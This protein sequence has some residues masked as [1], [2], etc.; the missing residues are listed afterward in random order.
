MICILEQT[1]PFIGISDLVINDLTAFE[2]LSNTVS[3]L[4][5]LPS[6]YVRHVYWSGQ[7]TVQST[8]TT[9]VV[10]STVPSTYLCNELME[11]LDSNMTRVLVTN[12]RKTS[13][14]KSSYKFLFAI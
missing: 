6:T 4:N 8:T 7:K 13:P 11:G 10:S 1:K 2:E 9:P 3:V 5:L 14:S 12:D